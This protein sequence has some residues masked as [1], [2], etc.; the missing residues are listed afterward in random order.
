MRCNHAGWAQ[1][2]TALK[3]SIQTLVQTTSSKYSCTAIVVKEVVVV[4]EA[5]VVEEPAGYTTLQT[6]LHYTTLQARQGGAWSAEHRKSAGSTGAQATA[7]TRGC[8]ADRHWLGADPPIL[9]ASARS[10]CRSSADPGTVTEQNSARGR[11]I[12]RARKCGVD[13]P[14]L[15]SISWQ[16]AARNPSN[17][18]SASN[19]GNLYR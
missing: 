18:T 17:N 6:T 2:Q 7:V 12:G 4:E 16:C 11:L 3:H 10:V 8:Q 9:H 5:A 15:G 19:T 14:V 1:A 13:G